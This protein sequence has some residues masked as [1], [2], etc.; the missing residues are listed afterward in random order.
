MTNSTLFAMRSNELER[1]ETVMMR[2]F[3]EAVVA[4]GASA[5]LWFW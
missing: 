2:T 4:I 1:K 3:S 5:E